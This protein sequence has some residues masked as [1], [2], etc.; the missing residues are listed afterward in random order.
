VIPGSSLEFQG[1]AASAT[2]DPDLSNN[3]DDT[4][5]SIVSQAELGIN[6]TSD[7]ATVNAGELVTYTITIMNVGP[8]DALFV[9]VKEQLPSGLTLQSISASDGGA[10]AGTLC[11]FGTVAVDDSR[12]VIVVAQ[13]DSAVTGVLTNTAAVD[14]ID[15]VAGLPVSTIATTTVNAAAVLSVTKVALNTPAYAGGLIH[16]QIVVANAGPSDAPNVVITDTLPV[17]T[18]YAGGDAT[19]NANGSTV[20]CA[21][22]TLAAGANRTLMVLATASV[23]LTNNARL[24]NTA[25]VTSPVAANPV[26]AT[27]TVT[28]LQPSGGLVNLAIT[29]TGPDT[30]AA[31]EY[32]TYTLVVT[33]SGPAIATN[34]QIVDALPY[35]IEARSVTST[36]GVCNNGIA[37]QLGDLAVDGVAVITI[38]G[39]VRTDAIS[40]TTVT[41]LANVSSNNPDENPDD[42]ADFHTHIIEA[43]AKLQI[44]KSA[45]PDTVAPGGALTYRIIV[46]NLGP[47]VARSVVVTDLFPTEVVAPLFT[48]A[49]GYCEQYTC[50]LG[51]VPVGENVT[52]L[53]IASVA[54]NAS[55]IF[56]NTATLTTT[57]ALHPDS[58]ITAEVGTKVSDTADLVMIK[59]ATPSTFAGSTFSYVLTV[60]N[61]GP[62]AALNVQIADTLPSDVEV[63][64]AGGCLFSA[65]NTV[66][67]PASPLPTLADGASISYTIVVTSSSSLL[68]GT[69]LQN[70]AE[71]A[72]DTFDPNPVNNLAFASTSIIGRSD[73]AI[74]KFAEPADV[75]AG[76]IL[77]YTVVISNRGPSD[78]VSVRLV[79]NLP[80]ETVLLGD[81]TV[82]RSSLIGVPV[83]CLGTVCE[84]SLMQVGESITF[85]LRTLVNPAVPHNMVIT[86]TVAVYSPSDPDFSNNVATRPVTVARES[87]LV[88]TKSATPVPAVTGAPLL[89]T[90]LVQNLGPSDAAGVVVTDALP[91]GF[92]LAAVSSSQGGCTALPCTLG[93]IAAGGSAY[94]YIDGVIDPLQA[95]SLVNT[96]SV[97][98][99]TPLTATEQTQTVI[100]TPVIAR[101][102]LKIVMESQATAIAG[103]T[104]TVHAELAN[105][106]PSSAAG[107]VMTLTLPPSTTFE[108]AVLPPDWY[109]STTPAGDIVVTTTL[110]ITPGQMYFFDFVVGLDPNI[111][112]G[113]SLEIEGNVS[114]LTPDPDLTN[115]MADTDITVVTRAALSISKRGAPDPATAGM[116][117]TYTVVVTNNGPSAARS[118]DI[119]DQLPA[120]LTL[121][122]V[123]A[124][125]GGACAGTLCQYGI[126]PA[127]ATRTMTVVAQIGADVGP[128]LVENTAAVYSPDSIQPTP[129]VVTETTT[130]TT[131]ATLR[132]AKTALHEPAVAGG[133]ALYQIVVT[134]DGPSDAQN[135]VVTDTLPLSTTYAGGDAAC[136]ANGSEI[137][138][139]V[140]TLA[141][142]ATRT[143]LVQVN[144]N[145]HIPTGTMLTNTVVASSPTAAL[146]T[147]ATATNT[148][149]QP[150]GG[151]ADVAI[152]KV[153]PATV[154]AGERITY[155]LAVTNRGPAPA[156]DVQIVD[157]LPDGVS[158]VS[159]TAS[160]GVCA[161]AVNCQLGDLALNATATVTIVGLVDSTVVSGT[162]LTNLAQVNSANEDPASANNTD[163]ATTTVEQLSNITMSKHATPAMATAGTALVYRIVVTNAGPSVAGGVVV[164]DAL[165][166]GF[167]ATSITSSQGNC[168]ALPCSVGDLAA[169]ATVV[170]TVRGFVESDVTGSLANSASITAT[171]PLTG[172]TATTLT[173]PVTTN[174]DLSLVLA[175]TPTSI[176]GTTAVVTATVTNA[177]PSDA[178]GAVVTL[179]LPAG[180][181]FDSATLPGGWF[182]ADNGDGTVTLTTT[183]ALAPNETVALPV[184]VDIASDVIPGTSLEFQGVVASSTSDPDVSNNSANSDTS[185]VSQA[186]LSIRKTSNPAAVNAG[187]LVTYTITIT[188]S[189]PSDARFVD[190][191]EQLPA[192][193]TL[194]SITASDGGACAGTLCQFGTVEADDSRTVTVVARV[195]SDLTGVV[196][197]TAAVDSIDNAAGVPVTATA[198]TT[199]TT[200]ATL[201]MTK[202]ALHEPAV[203]GGVALYQIVVTNDGP[204]DAQNVVVT[205]TLPLSTTYAGGDTACAANGDMVTCTVGTLAAGA[206]RTLLVQV[207]VNAHIPAGTML[208]NTV[209]ASSPTA[210]LT[211]TATATNTVAQP[212]GGVADV[213]ISKVGPATVTAGERITY[214]LVVTNRGPAPAQDVQIVDALPDGRELCQRDGEPGCVRRCGELSTGRPVPERHGHGDHRRPG[215]KHG[216]EWDNAHEPGAGEQRQ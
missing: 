105:R 209:V 108:S 68:P 175:S 172:A 81:V 43:V 120:G 18:T 59:Q 93:T 65:P 1:V 71:V 99:T 109:V 47:A 48:S 153:G 213:A 80:P 9:D 19:C 79:D 164:S 77:T 174:A 205:D 51:D 186:A 110:I 214:T 208:T 72:S 187:E 102:D 197:N 13:V 26:T 66:R 75:Q 64:D 63:A 189:G 89:Y 168:S 190:V 82:Q 5:T 2:S 41:N 88:I 96:A 211:T 112:S 167:T 57:T 111:R 132:M 32:V 184:T 107:T 28:V 33:N 162:T 85:T 3:A 83:T 143:L 192:G 7:P 195:N 39:F 119:K 123:T 52:L 61:L 90:I 140:G 31:G 12:T 210:A 29:K 127:N 183:N 95:L 146:T 144:V 136:A 196:T 193:L 11:Q 6:K 137:V 87:A 155:T 73:L 134:N 36:Q 121:F 149:A 38:S 118:V 117:V 138:C 44:E 30:A 53:V 147:T 27:A 185:I 212:V 125:D 54:D 76:A 113:T 141:A 165:P 115:N 133:V 131:A 163:I 204:S 94:V 180:V 58:V 148:V 216:R 152:S 139:S 40:G 42:N 46:R 4:D 145:A 116:H 86:N 166:T 23:S 55:G 124:S 156:Q 104:A 176:A 49:R 14:S 130:I 97:S 114:S 92:I 177:G 207:N 215:G 171:T 178:L 60:R 10:C 22:G 129:T 161:G 15:N 169:G 206:T 122:S 159:A 135:V 188:N 35:V 126:V 160:Q 37:C 179:T 191:K 101:A 194:Q 201:R 74:A 181:T 202:T 150:A 128:G 78:G 24:T 45:Q 151:V 25:T 103:L 84:T 16:Y 200:A 17:S 170:V 203:A 21:I 67:C 199:I 106:G 50:F 173:T 8:S 198:T 56:T 158:F 154:T 98:A 69:V 62:S 34:V 157:A 70:R 142:G 91:A 100:T 182:A 20:V